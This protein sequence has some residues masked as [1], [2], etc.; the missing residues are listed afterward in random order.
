MVISRAALRRFQP[1]LVRVRQTTS[2]RRSVTST[3][4]ICDS[5]RKSS[6]LF[7]RDSTEVLDVRNNVVVLPPE[8]G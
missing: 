4:W 3:T 7:R 5:H 6:G 1:S 8:R 2:R